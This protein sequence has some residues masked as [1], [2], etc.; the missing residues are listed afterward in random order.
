MARPPKN[1]G[2]PNASTEP[3]AAVQE[4]EHHAKEVRDRAAGKDMIEGIYPALGKS[5]AAFSDDVLV[6]G[7]DWEVTR[8]LEAPPP[9]PPEVPYPES[10]L[11]RRGPFFKLSGFGN[12]VLRVLKATR[13][14]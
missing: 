8:P 11:K 3:S 14:F 9:P 7:R 2:D 5:P 10:W 1:P 6:R 4:T 13:R 12:A